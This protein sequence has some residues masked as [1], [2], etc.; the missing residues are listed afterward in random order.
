[1]IAPDVIVTSPKCG[2]VSLP[3]NPFVSNRYHFGMLLGVADFDTEQ[4]YHRGKGWLHNAWLHG[5]GAVWGLRVEI[6]AERNEVL[7]QS[8]LAIDHRGRELYVAETM[9]LDLGRW[10]AERRPDDLEVEEEPDGSIRFTV[11]VELCHDSCLDRPVPSISEPCSEADLDTAYS[12]AVE[13][14]VPRLVGG[15]VPDEAPPWYPRLRQFFGHLPVSDPLVVE[16][17][18]AVA[19]AD[20]DDQ[21]AMC[22]LELRRLAAEDTMELHPADGAEPWAPVTGTGCIVLAEIAVHLVPD[23]EDF[24]IVGDG[25]EPTT[26]DNQVRP[27]HVRTTTVQELLCRGHEP[28]RA[29]AGIG[30]RAVRGSATLDGDELQLSFTA[31]LE[32]TTVVAS[33]FDVSVLTAAGWDQV[34][35]TAAAL[36]A[37]GQTVTLTLV[38]SPPDRPARVVARGTGPEPLVG[39]DAL[40]L[41][42]IEGDPVVPSG[43]DA[44]LMIA[45]S[46]PASDL[47][48]GRMQ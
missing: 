38:S 26:V 21:G 46:D 32:P 41:S 4:G 43:A 27:S 48:Q 18:D 40:P 20:P 6:V 19:S 9:C 47:E 10:Y 12:R 17:L 28:A 5:P 3:V 14:G 42:G 35:V 25:P 30:P 45:A 37:S 13:R 39:V 16:A 29:A 31:P 1:M 24:V 36:D 15:P 33:A 34:G 8:G 7:V 44:A 2:D 11:H 22:V 23:G